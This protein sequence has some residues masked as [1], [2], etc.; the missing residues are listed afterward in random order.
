[1]Y[2][3]SSDK[4]LSRWNPLA[5]PVSNSAFEEV[6]KSYRKSAKDN[7]TNTRDHDEGKVDHRILFDLLNEALSTVLGPPVTMSRFR[8]KIISCS[9]LPPLRGRKLLDC[10]WEIICEYLYPFSDKSYYS[11]DS[12]VATNLGSTPWFGLIDDEVNALGKDVESLIFGD[13]IDEVVKNM[14]L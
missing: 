1:M 12:M 4:C 8:R 5:K 6:E 7:E 3:E 10:V 9:M 2:D 14:H 11:L 13:L